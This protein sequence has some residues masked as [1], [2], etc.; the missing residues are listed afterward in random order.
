MVSKFAFPNKKSV[1]V[2]N[3]VMTK[4]MNVPKNFQTI[5]IVLRLLH[6]VQNLFV[7]L[8]VKNHLEHVSIRHVSAMDMLTVLINPMN[9]QL[10]AIIQQQQQF[11]LFHRP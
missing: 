1:M 3:I 9:Q 10:I 2:K 8:Q 5:Q 11:Q 4:P 7:I 6:H